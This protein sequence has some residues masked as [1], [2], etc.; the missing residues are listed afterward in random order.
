MLE[1]RQRVRGGARVVVERYACLV[2]R[3]KVGGGVE[4]S[5]LTADE[6]PQSARPDVAATVD[7][8][9]VQ[10]ARRLVQL[11]NDRNA[12]MKSSRVAS[13]EKNTLESGQILGTPC[14]TD[15]FH[16][17][18]TLIHIIASAYL[19]IMSSLSHHLS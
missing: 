5:Q 19:I 13:R 9:A 2:Q 10:P 4:S 11:N 14:T 1:L 12:T 17:L 18:N 16:F 8:V 6:R 7:E 15:T 3:G